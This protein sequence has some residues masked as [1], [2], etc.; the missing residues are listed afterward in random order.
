MHPECIAVSYY[1]PTHDDVFWVQDEN[2]LHTISI[3]TAVTGRQYKLQ[4]KDCDILNK[5]VNK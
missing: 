1:W 3:A 5:I 2:I 4:Q